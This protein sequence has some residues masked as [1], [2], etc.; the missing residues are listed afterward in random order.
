MGARRK[1]IEAAA[2]RQTAE[3]KTLQKKKK[4]ADLNRAEEEIPESAETVNLR[5]E[6]SVVDGHTDAH[7]RRGKLRRKS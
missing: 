6:R 3:R 2:P 4:S 7:S 1:K 5:S